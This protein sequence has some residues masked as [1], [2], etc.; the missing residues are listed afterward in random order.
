[1][2]ERSFMSL[3]RFR[4]RPR[5]DSTIDRNFV[6]Q[7]LRTPG[8]FRRHHPI[9]DFFEPFTGCVPIEQE[10][11]FIGSRS[12]PH[13]TSSRAQRSQ[14]EIKTEIPPVNEE[15][16]EWI[17]ALM[18]VYDAGD[19]YT[20][21]EL[22]AGYG[23]WGVRCGLAAR[24]KMKRAVR[25]FFAEAEPRHVIWLR[26]HTELNG[27]RETEVTLYE[28]AVS[29]KS[30]VTMFYVGT[31]DE[32]GGDLPRKW[33]GQ[34]ITKGYEIRAAAPPVAEVYE[35]HPVITHASGSKSIEIEQV[36]V[37]DVID[38]WGV[39]DFLDLDVQGEEAKIIKRAIRKISSN[40]KR[41]HIGTHGRDL[42]C[43]LRD[44]LSSH[45]WT[46]VRDYSCGEINSTP[47]GEV[48]FE[49]GVQSW[50]NPRFRL[51]WG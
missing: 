29:N 37:A 8:P 21:V 39:V 7:E 25:I 3:F 49:D 2:R 38:D 19:T 51:T 46:N 27:F 22:G 24:T 30:G 11:D 6:P 42:E 14:E 23:R 31:P 36:D 26:D 16:F 18:S 43:E 5:A 47:Y 13:Y 45:G 41:L 34:A 48:S 40:V 32:F 4:R 33:Y 10:I 9:F 20:A 1:M 35:G 44:V 15:Y 12:L 28:A 50:I 17:D